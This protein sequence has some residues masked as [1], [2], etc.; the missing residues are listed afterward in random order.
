[1]QEVYKHAARVIVYLGEEGHTRFD[2]ETVREALP[3]TR[4]DPVPMDLITRFIGKV[5]FERYWERLWIVQEMLLGGNVGICIQESNLLLW[6]DFVRCTDL[7]KNARPEI[8]AN[9][10]NLYPQAATIMEAKVRW[11]EDRLDSRVDLGFTIWEALTTFSHQK[12]ENKRDKIYALFGIL[13]NRDIRVSYE[14][15]ESWTN[16]DLLREVLKCGMKEIPCR[17]DRWDFHEFVVRYFRDAEMLN[18]AQQERAARDLF[19][20]KAEGAW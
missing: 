1:M 15:K 4:F 12:C 5:M 11:D 3:N 2:L 14:E 7:L 8:Y 18:G 16:M 10:S 9:Y 17:P 20:L 13:R 6:S 19:F